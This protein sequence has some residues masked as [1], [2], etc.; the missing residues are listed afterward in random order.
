[1]TINSSTLIKQAEDQLSCPLNDEVAI[2]SLKNTQYYSL[3]G[4]GSFVWQQLSELRSVEDLWTS[5]ADEF[6]VAD[7]HFKVEIMEFLNELLS[8]GLIE[9]SVS[10]RAVQFSEL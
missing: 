9:T 4:V 8:A 6:D 7:N 1:M 10:P 3:G 5:I 2:L